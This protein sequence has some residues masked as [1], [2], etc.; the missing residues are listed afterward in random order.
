MIDLHQISQNPSLLEDEVMS[1][2]SY[3]ELEIAQHCVMLEGIPKHIPKE[4]VESYISK[5]FKELLH[6]DKIDE[7]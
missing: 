7:S 6:V 1:W 3:S 2:K 5:I 4:K